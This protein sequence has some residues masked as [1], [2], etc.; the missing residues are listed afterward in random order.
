MNR[1]SFQGRLSPTNKLL[2]GRYT[3]LIDA[4]N[5]AGKRSATVQLTFTIAS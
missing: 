2:P 4:R 3:L 1:V 5:S